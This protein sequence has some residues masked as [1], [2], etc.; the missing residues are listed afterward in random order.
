L[1]ASKTEGYQKAWRILHCVSCIG[2]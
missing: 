2:L 1:K